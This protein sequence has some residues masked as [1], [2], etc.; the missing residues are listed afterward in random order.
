[1]TENEPKPEKRLILTDYGAA[2]IGEGIAFA[3]LCIGLGISGDAELMWGLVV[4]WAMCLGPWGRDRHSKRDKER[5][6]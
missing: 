1:M 2:W 5:I 3:G 4:I 6:S